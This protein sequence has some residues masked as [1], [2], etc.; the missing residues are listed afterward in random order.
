[1]ALVDII[2]VRRDRDADDDTE[3][4]EATASAPDA[5]DSR[6]KASSRRKRGASC[7]SRSWTSPKPSSAR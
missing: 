4:P 3:A 5:A 2:D 7:C 1:V 6:R